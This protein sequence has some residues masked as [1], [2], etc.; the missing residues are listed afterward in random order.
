[1]IERWVYRLIDKHPYRALLLMPFLVACL[2]ILVTLVARGL[3]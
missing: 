1:M 3:T 2:L